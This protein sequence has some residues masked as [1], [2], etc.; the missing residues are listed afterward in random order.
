MMI[1]K[2]FPR[3]QNQTKSFKKITHP[4]ITEPKCLNNLRDILIN[5]LLIKIIQS[6]YNN[7]LFHLYNM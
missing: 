3:T 6:I 1:S 7:K 4:W 5:N 2:G